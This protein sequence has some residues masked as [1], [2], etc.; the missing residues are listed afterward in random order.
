MKYWELLKKISEHEDIPTKINYMGNTY[1][2]A[3]NKQND[4]IDYYDMGYS[5][6]EKIACH[7]MQDQGSLELE[8]LNQT[9]NIWEEH[10]VKSSNS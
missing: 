4:V 2:L 9:I 1:K 10:N 8:P 6:S 5:L 3:F 7:L